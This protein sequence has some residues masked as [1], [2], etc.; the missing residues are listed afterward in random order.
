M[1]GSGILWVSFGC[2][3]C[4]SSRGVSVEEGNVEL[5][6]YRADRDE[7]SWPLD[8]ELFVPPLPLESVSLLTP[9]R[10]VSWHTDYWD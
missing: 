4:R 7:L 5:E 1:A 6:L 2:G 3:L 8:A 9:Y 10:Y